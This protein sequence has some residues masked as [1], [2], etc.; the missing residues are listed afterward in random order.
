MQHRSGTPRSGFT[1]PM[2]TEL[3]GVVRSMIRPGFA[4][5]DERPTLCSTAA[6]AGGRPVRPC[7]LA[8]VAGLNPPGRASPP[9][10]EPTRAR[11]GRVDSIACVPAAAAALA[12]P[13][14][15]AQHPPVVASITNRKEWVARPGTSS[16]RKRLRGPRHQSSAR[17]A[18]SDAGSA[19]RGAARGGSTVSWPP[20]LHHVRIRSMRANTCA[21]S[22]GETA[23]GH[24]EAA[25]GH[26]VERNAL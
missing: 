26:T 25:V 6:A 13:H 1:T 2:K 18:I 15:Y 21:D 4:L 20:P 24:T 5:L 23:A 19:T 14:H 3:C 22:G 8:S 17:G 16:A 9:Y 11:A 7:S 12:A 10:N